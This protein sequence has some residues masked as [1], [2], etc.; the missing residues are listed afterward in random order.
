MTIPMIKR[1]VANIIL[2]S[3]W[4]FNSIGFCNSERCWL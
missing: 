3:I 4:K 2:A 1:H